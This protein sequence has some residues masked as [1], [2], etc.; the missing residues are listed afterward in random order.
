MEWW[1]AEGI[2]IELLRLNW[3]RK[4]MLR[5]YESTYLRGRGAIQLVSRRMMRG[6][7]K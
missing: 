7:V 4:E 3:Y 5:V 2:A 1:I 6:S